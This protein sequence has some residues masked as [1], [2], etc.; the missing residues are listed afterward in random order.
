MIPHFAPEIIVCAVYKLIDCP[1]TPM[2]YNNE[3][4]S[5]SRHEHGCTDS[6][7]TMYFCGS[8]HVDNKFYHPSQPNAPPSRS[9]HFKDQSTSQPA[10][11]STTFTRVHD[12][13][14]S[15]YVYVFAG[16]R[17]SLHVLSLCVSARDYLTTSSSVMA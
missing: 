7:V 9:V 8:F 11:L 4:V 1:H 13:S 15:V 17:P 6:L 5:S 12:R 16:I 10:N 3:S 14:N 2:S